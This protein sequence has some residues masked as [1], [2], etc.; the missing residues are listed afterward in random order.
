MITYRVG[1]DLPVEAVIAVL[2]ASTLAA[3]RPVDDPPI[4]AD[5][6]RHA[7]LIVSA[8]DGERLIGFARTLT[9]FSYVGYLSDLAVDEGHQRQGIGR[10]LIEL[11]REQMG[12]RSFLVLLAA[13]AAVEYYPHLGFHPHPSAWILRHAEPLQG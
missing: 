10:K 4:I 3:R 1:S 11:T 9:D 12:P 5:M 6:I 7:S 8:W 2:K 13:P